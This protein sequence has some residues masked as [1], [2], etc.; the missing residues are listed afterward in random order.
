MKNHKFEY[1]RLALLARIF[2]VAVGLIALKLCEMQVIY[3]DWYRRAAER[4]RTQVIFQTAPRGRIID[5]NGQLVATNRSS[6]NLIFLPGKKTD[7]Q[8][9]QKLARELSPYLAQKPEQIL[10]V[11]KD[12]HYHKIPVRLAE[13]LGRQ[14][15]FRLAELKT[16]FP[17]VDL[18]LEARRFYPRGRFASHLLGYMGEMDPRHWRILRQRGDYRQDVRIGKRGLEELFEQE[19]K[20]EEGG[21][22]LEVD[23]QG[24]LQRVLRTD[25]WTPG[26]DIIVTLDADLQQVAED[27]L[28]ASPSGAGAVVAMDPF[29]GDIL[30]LASVPDYDP[31]LFL[32]PRTPEVQEALRKI[33]EFNLAIQG[34]YPP[35]SIFKIITLLAAFDSGRA[36]P[37]VSYR[38]PGY[39]TFGTRTFRCWKKGGHGALDMAGGLVHSC[40]VYFYQLALKTGALV[41]ENYARQFRIGQ[42]T[43]FP[44]GAESGGNAFGPFSASQKGQR[45]AEGDTLNLAIGQGELLVTPMQMAQMIAAVA[46]GGTL[47]RPRLV[48]QIRSPAGQSLFKQRIEVLGTVQAGKGSWDFLRSSLVKVVEEGTGHSSYIAGLEIGGKTG[49][50]Q[51]PLGEDHAWFVA[52]G[53]EPGAPPKIAVAVLVQH[54]GHG[55]VAAA[56]VA[57][58][59][60]SRMLSRPQS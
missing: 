5:R 23:A 30:V 46:N 4:N 48:R 11:L 43:H 52:Y 24:R 40:D 19:L 39:Y 16:L 42:V 17:G 14:T 29:S 41:I 22:H 58:K 31:N 18:V 26:N 50:A 34:S 32:Q 15:M 49:T 10:S 59:I 20:G 53:G 36:S 37:E 27:A 54:G 28:R 57:R 6:F 9:L 33:P 25:P 13:N 2:Y 44:I 21:L 38:C 47:W 45:W 7:W 55:S 12:A 8:Y 56:P 3:G 51:N 1:S 60:I 35:G